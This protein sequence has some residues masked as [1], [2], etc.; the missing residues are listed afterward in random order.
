METG[1]SGIPGV[2]DTGTEESRILNAP[3]T[4]ELFFDKRK[5]EKNLVLQSL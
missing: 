5:L 1:E 3:V 4:R 2:R